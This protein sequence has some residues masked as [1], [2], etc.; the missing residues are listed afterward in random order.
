VLRDLGARLDRVNLTGGGSRPALWRQILADVLGL[1]VT[2][3]EHDHGAALG[4]AFAAGMGTGAFRSWDAGA[5]LTAVAGR[6][7]PDPRTAGR[8]AEFYAVYRSLYP[9][10]VEQQHALARLSP[11]GPQPS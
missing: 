2:H 8:Y 10:L 9:A 3:H 4:A 1:P 6:T 11:A 7:E 5:G